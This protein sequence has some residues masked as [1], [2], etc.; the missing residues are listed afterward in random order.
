MEIN[1]RTEKHRTTVERENSPEGSLRRCWLSEVV[2]RKKMVAVGFHVESLYTVYVLFSIDA[3][4][5][6]HHH[7]WRSA[8]CSLKPFIGRQFFLLISK[9]RILQESTTSIHFSV[10]IGC[11]SVDL[12]YMS[13]KSVVFVLTMKKVEVQGCCILLLLQ[14]IF[15]FK[16]K[17]FGV[18]F[19]KITFSAYA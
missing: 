2:R 4:P 7:R 18:A 1:H 3:L 15:T 6:N 19:A 8:S 13:N 10:L 17:F 12:R 14:R 11:F 5:H 16:Q 9:P